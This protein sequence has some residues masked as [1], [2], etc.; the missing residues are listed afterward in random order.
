M[1]RIPN[2]SWCLFCHVREFGNRL[3][4]LKSHLNFLSCC[5][6]WNLVA[7][8]FELKNAINLGDDNLYQEI[9]HMLHRTSQSIQTKVR[10][11]INIEIRRVSKD[12]CREKQ[13]LVWG[14]GKWEGERA[15]KRIE[16]DLNRLE[17]NLN[18][19]KGNK[20]RNLQRKELGLAVD[21]SSRGRSQPRVILGRLSRN[22]VSE[23]LPTHYAI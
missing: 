13:E 11:W 8:G 9:K 21:N 4:R 6:T 5:I 3:V 14:L 22:A 2:T 1:N 17:Y 18:R 10:D 20:I 19:T 16:N 23:V 12:F 7:T 15:I